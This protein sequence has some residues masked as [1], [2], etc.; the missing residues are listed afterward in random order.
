[1]IT[2]DNW[3]ASHYSSGPFKAIISYG[4]GEE[5][6]LYW[7]TV[8]QGKTQEVFQREFSKLPLALQTINN[9]YGHWNFVDTTKPLGSGCDSCSNQDKQMA[10]S[11]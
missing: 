1:M 7:L 6:R 2:K 11:N 10:S 4:G 3:N 8:L 5:E 9:R